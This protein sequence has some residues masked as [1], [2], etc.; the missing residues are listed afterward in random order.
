[1]HGCGASR[2]SSRTYRWTYD[3]TCIHGADSTTVPAER[4]YWT[5]RS[6]LLIGKDKGGPG[7]AWTLAPWT[8]RAET[9]SDPVR[10]IALTGVFGLVAGFFGS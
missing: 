9:Q 5:D 8:P 3:G 4:T 6:G 2:T 7:Q 10:A 1:M